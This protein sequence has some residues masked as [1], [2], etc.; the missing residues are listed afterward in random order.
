MRT[1]VQTLLFS[2]IIWGLNTVTLHIK[3]HTK[4]VNEW[5]LLEGTIKLILTKTPNS[6]NLM[7]KLTVTLEKDD[8]I[9]V[10]NGEN[11]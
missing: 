10:R 9:E 1:D 4:L 3:E 8:L 11:K 2:A 5:I 6:A 7:I